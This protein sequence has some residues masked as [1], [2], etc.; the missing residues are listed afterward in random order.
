M[1]EQ[2]KKL[3]AIN[4]KLGLLFTL[5]LLT[6]CGTNKSSSGY[7]TD[8]TKANNIIL[9]IGDGMGIAQISSGF[10]AK[11]GKMAITSMPVVGFHKPNSYDDLITDSA[12]GATAFACGVKTYNGA[13][14]VTSDT[15][16]CYSILEELE[17]LNYGTGLIATSTI[18]HATPASFIAHQPMRIMYEQIAEDFLQTD[19][20]LFIGG[21]KRYFDRRESDEKNL[22]D[23]LKNKDYYV[24]DYLEAE[25]ELIAPPLQ[26]KFAYFAADK[27]PLTHSA[28]R[29][30]LPQA[31]AL[32]T[33]FLNKR[34]LGRFFLVVEGSQIDWGGHANDKE[35][36]IDEVIDFDNAVREAIRFAKRDG[37]TLVI[38]T[39]DH[40]CG[41]MSLMTASKDEEDIDAAFTTNGHTA[42]LVP[43]FAYGPSAGRFTGIYKNTDIY[44]KM[45]AALQLDPV[46]AVSSRK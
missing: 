37:N 28:G 33:D 8:F 31:T 42:T 24:S 9:L 5:L 41:G 45:R 18:V 46:P 44:D 35:L 26:Q 29:Y 38:V 3:I 27:H 39:A 10:Y 6:N 32:A 17:Q 12:A 34:S 4:S 2:N 36:I 20:D 16:P 40:E 21:G 15:T 25:L 13:I 7:E 43:V 30:Y 14:G 11:D 1:Q 23:K 19:I 22:I